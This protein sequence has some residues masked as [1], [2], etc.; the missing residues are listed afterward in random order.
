MLLSVHCSDNFSEHEAFK[1]RIAFRGTIV[2]ILF[3]WP[4][5]MRGAIAL[6]PVPGPE[7]PRR[8][9]RSEVNSKYRQGFLRQ[10][11]FGRCREN[12]KHVSTT[13]S[14]KGYLVSPIYGSRI[15][16]MRASSK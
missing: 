5:G 9:S 11:F 8:E 4:G 3:P 10:T 2:V 16:E 12:T 7:V 15:K 14:D 6:I 1:D 13:E